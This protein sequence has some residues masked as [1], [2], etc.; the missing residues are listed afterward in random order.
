MPLSIQ[1]SRRLARSVRGAAA[2]LLLVSLGAL[3]AV[4]WSERQDALKDGSE[5]LELMAR[6]L[7]DQATR[8]VETAA[9]ALRTVA[10]GMRVLPQQEAV[11]LQPLLAQALIAQPVLRGLAVLDGEGLVLASSDLREQGLRL[12]LSQFGALPGVGHDQLLPLRSGRDLRS[13]RHEPADPARSTAKLLPL[14]RRVSVAGGRELLLLALINPDALSNAQ[15]TAVGDDP[16]DRAALLSYGGELLAATSQVGLPLGSS[17]A[18]H[19]V[20][21][22]HLPRR[23]HGSYVGTGMESGARI[24]AYR[25]ARARPLVVLVEED[26]DKALRDW[27][28]GLWWLVAGGVASALVIIG[29]AL[30]LLANLKARARTRLEL[31]LAHER[32]ALR[33]RELSVLF[34]SVQELLFRTDAQGRLSFVNAHWAAFSHQGAEQALG[35]LMQDLVEPGDRDRVAR[36]FLRDEQ[37]GARRA[38]I[39][40]RAGDGQLRHF[41]M[42]VVPLLGPERGQVLG[43]AG[44]AVDVTERVLAEHGLKQ[45]LAFSGLL[46]EVSPQPISMTDLGG[47]YVVVNRAWEDFTGRSRHEVMG[48]PMGFFLP[49]AER[50]AQQ[51]QDEELLARGGRSAAE[52]QILHRD[53]TLR[54]VQISK[55]VVPDESGGASGILCTVTDVTKFRAAERATLQARDAAEEASRAKSEFI[56]NISHELR[57][58]L[59]SILGFSELGVARGQAAPKLAAM[60]GDIHAAGQRMLALVNDLL[61]VSKIESAVGTFHLERCDLRQLVA[62]VMQ[63]LDPLLARRGLSLSCQLPEHALPVK[64]DVLRIQQVLRNV[65]ANAIKFSPEGGAIRLD[66]EQDGQQV[67][68]VVADRGPGIPPAELEEIF[69]AFVQSSKTKD[70]S[71]G[72]GLGLA[73]SRK[74]LEIHGGSISAQNRAGGGACFHIHLPL[75]LP[76]DTQL[77]ALH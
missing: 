61:D 77:S 75:R 35:R 73:I 43:F 39:S 44:S 64:V 56:A 60:F 51:A 63:E 70:G 50:T 13:L 23:E 34:K 40:L 38:E 26:L 7:E 9:F 11:R 69:G 33:E 15:Q 65:L 45:Q 53:G 57:T 52:T 72:T 30:V 19:P 67:H 32:V 37:G 46:L 55:V 22:Q 6:V 31:D 3:V 8:S 41:Q 12:D 4:G 10:E 74:I 5:R 54:D 58:P 48:H 27:R 66:A 25:A 76:G 42:A 47:R 2:A 18:G 1:Q 29:A 20:F 28:D 68:I 62:P 36:L 49:A 16:G 17:L 71:G 14:V 21:Q 24:V 59:Q